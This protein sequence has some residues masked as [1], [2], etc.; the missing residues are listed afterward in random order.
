MA[1]GGHLPP[2]GSELELSSSST[3]GRADQQTSHDSN[4]SGAFCF[5]LKTPPQLATP[6][7]TDPS[8]PSALEIH[9][10]NQPRFAR[11]DSRGRLSPHG[12]RAEAVSTRFP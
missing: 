9:A 8:I 12:K 6:T 1:R 5:A 10:E 7:P 4:E 3:W 11:P 2:G